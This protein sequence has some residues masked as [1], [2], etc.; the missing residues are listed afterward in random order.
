[1]A[2]PRTERHDLSVPEQLDLV[3][4]PTGVG[5]QLRAEHE[6]FRTV[7]QADLH[8]RLI[9]G[10]P[11]NHTELLD[12]AFEPR[13]ALRPGLTEE[14]TSRRHQADNRE[15]E[16]QALEALGRR[17]RS[18][19]LPH[20]GKP[21]PSVPPRQPHAALDNV[22]RDRHHPGMIAS[23]LLL[24]L[25]APARADGT[26]AARLARKGRFTLKQLRTLSDEDLARRLFGDLGP[27]LSISPRGV[28]R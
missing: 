1:M 6:V 3:A 14:Q 15:H 13:A 8:D 9:A 21:A 25:A 2:A 23:A 5:E 11:R 27:S 18:E 26:A 17:Q 19:R 22:R 28:L 16:S 10:L 4:G 24:A 12:L 7:R 20:R